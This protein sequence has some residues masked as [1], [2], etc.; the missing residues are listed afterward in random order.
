MEVISQVHWLKAGYANVY[1]CVEEGG[2][3]LIDSGPP[4]QADVILDYLTGL[5]R[6]PSELRTI[7]ITHADWDHAGSVAALQ[8]RTGATIVVA[9]PAAAYCSPETR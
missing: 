1:L 6:E 3:A 7:L 2:V 5:G 4:K 8:A 9:P